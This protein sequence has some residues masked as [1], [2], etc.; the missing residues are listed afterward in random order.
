MTRI[1]LDTNVVLDFI[2]K[3]SDFAEDAA[4]IFDLGERK[5]LTLTL[6]SLSVNNIDY[7]VSKIESKKKARQV[8]IKLLSLVEILPVGK[9]TIEKSAMSEFKD[10]EDAI[11]N[12][13]AEEQGLNHIITRNLKDYRKSN[14]S[15]LSPK[16]FLT[17]LAIHEEE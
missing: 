4:I 8:I 13:C 12:F 5:K 14:L 17:S 2:L 11:Q 16:E 1:F 3:R 9:S 15:I 7:V 10:F 6:S